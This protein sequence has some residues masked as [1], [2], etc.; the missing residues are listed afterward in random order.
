MP[1]LW[2]P[3]LQ[4]P[5]LRRNRSRRHQEPPLLQ[6]LLQKRRVRPSR[7]H[8][9]SNA[10]HR[11]AG[12]EKPRVRLGH[13]KTG[14]IADAGTHQMEASNLIEAG[15]VGWHCAPTG[16]C[17]PFKLSTIHIDAACHRH[18][19][20]AAT[21]GLT[22][23]PIAAIKSTRKNNSYNCQVGGQFGAVY[24][25]GKGIP[26]LP[27]RLMAGLSS[28]NTARTCRTSGCARFGPRTL[29]FSISAAREF[30]QHTLVFD[31]SSLSGGGS[32]W[33]GEAEGDDP[34]EPGGGGE[35]ER[36]EAI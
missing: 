29:I 33:R 2:N 32:G 24:T 34:P 31:R 5:R 12:Y 9:S 30:F 16:T 19:A 21:A 6:S 15:R 28:S 7:R 18:A 20:K 27:T 14:S 22:A 35:D 26:P 13:E 17:L 4:R 36:A 10:E 25:D 23:T 11:R 8:P 3:A 1:V